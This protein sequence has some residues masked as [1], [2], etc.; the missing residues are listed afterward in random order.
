[1]SENTESAALQALVL[2]PVL[3]AAATAGLKPG[4]EAALVAGGVRINAGEVQRVTTQGL[5]LL[6]S[7][8]QNFAV[9]GGAFEFGTLSAPL[10]EASRVL[11]LSP[12][13][14]LEGE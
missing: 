12:L 10:C 5:Q 14:G 4:F 1:M 8:A 2:P 11:G 13:L 9:A 6:A 7:A 3:D